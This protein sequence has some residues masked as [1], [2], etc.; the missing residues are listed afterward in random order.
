MKTLVLAAQ[1]G[2]VAKTTTASEMAVA[3]KTAGL[4]VAVIDSDPQATLCF[5]SDARGA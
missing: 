4:A 1:K 5:W 3:A 2:G